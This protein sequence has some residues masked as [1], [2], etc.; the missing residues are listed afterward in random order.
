MLQVIADGYWFVVSTA[1]YTS[2]CDTKKE[3][4]E[5]CSTAG[6]SVVVFATVVMVLETALFVAVYRYRKGSVCLTS[7]RKTRQLEEKDIDSA[8]TTR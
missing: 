5:L 2:D 1:W 8:G 3:D 7:P 6:P 4:I